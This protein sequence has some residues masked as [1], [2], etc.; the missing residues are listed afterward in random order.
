VVLAWLEVNLQRT[1]VRKVGFDILHE[2]TEDDG[3]GL[4]GDGETHAGEAVHA[5]AWAVRIEGF[6]AVFVA[7]KNGTV[8]HVGF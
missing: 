3:K 6:V 4:A 5:K 2:M 8:E 1:D 7:T